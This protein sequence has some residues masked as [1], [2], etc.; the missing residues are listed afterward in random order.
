MTLPKSAKKRVPWLVP[1]GHIW[2]Q[3]IDDVS[4]NIKEEDVKP[5]INLIAR[6]QS[7]NMWW[8]AKCGLPPTLPFPCG[9]T[10]GKEKKFKYAWAEEDLIDGTSWPIEHTLEERKE[11]GYL[12]CHLTTSLHTHLGSP[13]P[14]LKME[15]SSKG[16]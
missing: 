4:R 5:L 13:S 8:A 7:R 2:G 14:S 15:F 1:Q 6:H 16:I 11:E 10:L 9:R 12:R 3:G